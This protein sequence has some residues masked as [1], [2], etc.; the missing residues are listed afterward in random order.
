MTVGSTT[1]TGPGGRTVSLRRAISTAARQVREKTAVLSTTG[2]GEGHRPG[3]PRPGTHGDHRL[4]EQLAGPGRAAEQPAVSGGMPGTSFLGGRR[5]R[6]LA[7][8]AIPGGG[9]HRVEQ[10]CCG[11]GD[12]HVDD[13]A[14]VRGALGLVAV[15]QG[16]RRG[17]AQHGGELP[18]RFC[19]SR[20]VAT[21][22]RGTAVSGCAGG[23]GQETRRSRQRRARRAWKVHR[24]RTI[25]TSSA[26]PRGFRGPRSSRPAWSGSPGSSMNSTGGGGPAREPLVAGR[27]GSPEHLRLWARRSR[28]G[29]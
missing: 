16:L 14:Y 23:R 19:T 28:V 26:R 11:G 8:R 2:R 24:A 12:G 9:G 20:S 18:H 1:R 10:A 25:S 17:A 21:S 6:G 13:L 29:E 5:S 4:R 3:G 27:R 15:Q 7:P 22:C